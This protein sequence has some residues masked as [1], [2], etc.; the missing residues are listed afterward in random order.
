VIH[1]GD[2]F[3]GAQ[4]LV[5]QAGR[6]M[7]AG[8]V[9]ND[10]DAN[11]MAAAGERL[12]GGIVV[13]LRT[14]DGTEVM[15]ATTTGNGEYAFLNLASGAY[16]VVAATAPGFVAATPSRLTVWAGPDGTAAADFGQRFVT[17]GRGAVAGRV[18]DDLDGNGRL[19]PAEPPLVGVGVRLLHPDGTVVAQTTTAGDGSYL[20]DVAAGI[21][22]LTLA[23]PAGFTWCMDCP[24]RLAVTGGQL[25]NAP[26]GLLAANAVGG[27]VFFDAD[28]DG[29]RSAGERGVG[30]ILIRLYA[31]GDVVVGQATTSAD[32]YYLFSG[33]AT[34][35]Y[36]VT[37]DRPRGLS[38]TTSPTRQVSLV[39]G[40]GAAASFGVQIIGTLNGVV[41]VDSNGNDRL[42][43]G[44]SGLSGVQVQIVMSGNSVVQTTTTTSG[45]GFQFA[46]LPA[47]V[48]TA[49]QS[50]PAGFTTERNALMT[51]VW[52]GGG[53]SA[54]FADR[55]VRTISGRVFHDP[56][57]N[58]VMDS[59]EPG[60][61]GVEVQL[62][63]P[64]GAMIVTTRAL[65]NGLFEF[66]DVPAGNYVVAL[67]AP[68]GFVATTPEQ[69]AIALAADDS[70]AVNFGLLAFRQQLYLP[71]V[72]RR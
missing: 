11:G 70:Q 55:P 69:V 59:Q 24:D 33:V 5:A 19:N 65:G 34:G 4:A 47:G 32:G 67:I 13:S 44:E 56:D 72:L 15:T 36:T 23:A 29:A 3:A 57:M 21:Y 10:A 16:E 41:F 18:F 7:I 45:G 54:A 39:G 31:A 42:D 53:G 6:A 40:R 46:G 25:S 1:F 8:R 26:F 62:R 17:P 60:F 9:Y 52:L 64:T 2:R 51:I 22:R 71:I 58:A 30:G 68:R 37:M 12:L 38:T 66:R 43:D 48:Y 61:G 35:I 28:G 14:L 20:F 50:V 27:A 63:T 49:T